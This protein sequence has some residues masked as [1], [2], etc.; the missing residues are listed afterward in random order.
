MRNHLLCLSFLLVGTLHAQP[1]QLVSGDD[2]KPYADSKLPEGGMTTELTK[3]AFAEVKKEVQ[4]SWLPWKR[5]YDEAKLGNF[6]ATFP[7]L[8]TP[9]R[10]QDFYYSD[11]LVK[12]QDFPFVKNGAKN[13]NFAKPDTLAGTTICLPLGWAPT[14]KLVNLIKNKSIK[15]ESPKDLSTCV[16]MVATGRADYFITDEAQG[17]ATVKASDV[18][19]GNI[20][21]VNV[22]MAETNLYL[23]ASKSASGSKELLTSFNKGLEMLRKNGSYDKVVKAHAYSK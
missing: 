8:K 3:K 7:Y 6:A 22:A 17:L 10:E 5:G 11:V 13:L 12:I 20:S 15:V 2:Y 16:K 21:M 4:L 23:I 9:D 14:P 19:V 1:I 18:G